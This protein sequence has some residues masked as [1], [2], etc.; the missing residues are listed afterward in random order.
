[1]VNDQHARFTL[2]RGATGFFRPKEGPLPETGLRAFRAALYAAARAVGGRVS[3]LEERAYP[4]TF[5]SAEVTD[6]TGGH[7]ILCHAHH[8]WV[9]F[10]EERRDWYT[11]EF[12]APPPWA[13]GFAHGGFQVLDHEQLTM[14]LSDVDTSVMTQGEWRYVRLYGITTL[15]GVLFNAWN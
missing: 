14:P 13:L 2:P 9:A 15:G 4:R 7:V 11:E 10:A 6:G 12:Q 5:H 3:D 1:M 8:P